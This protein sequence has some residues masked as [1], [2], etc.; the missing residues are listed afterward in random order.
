M[1]ILAQ[2][3]YECFDRKTKA[4]SA[5]MGDLKTKTDEVDVPNYEEQELSNCLLKNKECFT[6]DNGKQA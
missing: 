5:E 6:E 2:D 4:E 3:K 1:F